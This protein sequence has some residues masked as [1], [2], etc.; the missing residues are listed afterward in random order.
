MVASGLADGATAVTGGTRP[1]LDKGFFV[2]P[3]LL[4]DATNQ[5]HVAREEIFGPVVVVIPFEDEEEGIAIAN[6]SAYGLYGY[7]FSGDTS[8]GMA[9]ARRLRSGNVGINTANRNPETPFGGVKESG[10]GRDGGSFA[11]HAYTEW[12]SMVWPS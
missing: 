1:D 5:M 12:Q 7:V 4:A 3:T 9:V 8:H 6:D 10:M 11:M 2:A